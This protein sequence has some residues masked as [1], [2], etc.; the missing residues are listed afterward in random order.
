MKNLWIILGGVAVTA[1]T[2]TFFIWQKQKKA[3]QIAETARQM[4]SGGILD[5]IVRRHGSIT[6]PPIS[7][8]GIDG[9]TGVYCG[10]CR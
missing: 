9:F 1:A 7:G 6:T 5:E 10:G 3:A 8:G 2:A 4:G